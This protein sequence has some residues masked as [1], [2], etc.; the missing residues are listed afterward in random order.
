MITGDLVLTGLGDV[1]RRFEAVDAAA[2]LGYL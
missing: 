2:T 1:S